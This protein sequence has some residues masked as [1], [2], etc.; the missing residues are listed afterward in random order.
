M[1]KLKK[2]ETVNKLGDIACPHCGVMFITDL[3]TKV[4]KGTFPCPVCRRQYVVTEEIKQE[5]NRNKE[6]YRKV[7]HGKQK[8]EK[9]K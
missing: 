3:E 9:A 1:G 7:I 6:A 4:L 8:K 2:V 5:A